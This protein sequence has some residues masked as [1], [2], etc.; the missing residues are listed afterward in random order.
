MP[1]CHGKAMPSEYTP[2]Q[3]NKHNPLP[4]P[5]RCLQELALENINRLKDAHLAPLAALSTTLRSLSLSACIN[6]GAAKA[7]APTAVAALRNLTAL[8]H[9]DLSQSGFGPQRLRLLDLQPALTG[10]TSLSLAGL[11]LDDASCSGLEALTNLRSLDLS[12]ATITSEFMEGALGNCTRLTALRLAWCTAGALPV[13]GSLKAL[14][15]SRGRLSNVAHSVHGGEMRLERLRCAAC[16]FEGIAA[17]ALP[18]IVRWGL[19]R[20]MGGAGAG[21]RLTGVVWWYAWV[22]SIWFVSLRTGV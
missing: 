4:P 2:S 6:I 13:I 17:L 22:T 19:R 12:D 11:Q 7:S 14:D 15:V 5:A 1:S 10:L 16:R 8:R 9:L 21:W 20:R 3:P 18:E